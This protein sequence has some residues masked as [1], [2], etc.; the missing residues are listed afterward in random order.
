MSGL[1][2]FRGI[3]GFPG[4]A[5]TTDGA[6]KNIKTGHVLTLQ[7]MGGYLKA[8]VAGRGGYRGA[9][10]LVA[11]A[12]LPPDPDPKRIYVN[13]LDGNKKNNVVSN[14]EWCTK[15]ENLH[16]ARETGL[17]GRTKKGRAVES[18]NENGDIVRYASV[19]EAARAVGACDTNIHQVLNKPARKC[20][21]L[22]WRTPNDLLLPEERWVPVFEVDGVPLHYRRYE[23]ST[24]GRIRGEYGLLLNQ[25]LH[26]DGCKRITLSLGNEKTKDMRSHRLIAAGFLGPPPGP[27]YDVDHIDG[28]PENNMPSNLQYL[29]RKEHGT[30]TCGVPVVQ[31]T[32]DGDFVAEFPSVTRAAEAMQRSVPTLCVAIRERST[33]AG[34]LWQKKAL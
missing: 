21:G 27:G 29:N 34:Y 22:T 2:I 14:L 19:R 5:V 4:Y 11:L 10:V 30:K 24:L 18:V 16:H 23:V 20:W 9:H 15:A 3:P 1:G 13:H 33:C 17:R 6:V 31:S 32:L 25:S 8:Q 7:T 12:W 26:L 28:D